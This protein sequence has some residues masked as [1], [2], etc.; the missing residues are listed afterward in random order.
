MAT[1]KK[2]ARMYQVEYDKQV[3]HEQ[4]AIQRHAAKAAG[5]HSYSIT[6]APDCPMG[7]HQMSALPG[8]GTG[9]PAGDV[10]EEKY[11]S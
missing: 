4:N 6:G 10:V 5:T 9:Q 7:S 3:E 11:R 8:H 2:E 1:E